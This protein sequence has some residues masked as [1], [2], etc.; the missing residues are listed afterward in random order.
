L[1]RAVALAPADP[2]FSYVLAVAVA[3]SGDRTEAIRVQEATLKTRPNDAN[4]LRALAGYLRDL[5]QLEH[6]TVT[7]QKLEM[8]MRE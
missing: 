4:A 1:K 8:L 7:Q 3:E 5:G 2:R 6:A